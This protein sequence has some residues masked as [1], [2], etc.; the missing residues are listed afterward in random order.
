[1][2]CGNCGKKLEDGYVF[3]PS[4]GKKAFDIPENNESAAHIRRQ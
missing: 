4:C 3:C 2:F 1:M